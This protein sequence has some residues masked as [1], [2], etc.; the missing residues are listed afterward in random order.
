VDVLHWVFKVIEHNRG[1][2][3]A[4]L[5]I[6]AMFCYVG[7]EPTT[8]SPI[9][10]EN[11]TAERLETE[12]RAANVGYTQRAAQLD[13]EQAALIAEMEATEE[14]AELARDILIQKY[15][16][17]AALLTGLGE[18]AIGLATG[19][20]TPVNAAGSIIT[21]GLAALAGGSIYDGRRKDK[22]LAAKKANTVST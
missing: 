9:S 21:L 17:R 12:V 18:F 6:I 1:K 16:R 19:Q 20:V 5:L 14:G 7:C 11:V 2:A 13:A 3:I 22:V 8:I 4:V 10:G 15:E